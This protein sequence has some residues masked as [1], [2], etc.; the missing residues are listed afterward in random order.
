MLLKLTIFKM[1]GPMMEQVVVKLLEILCL[2]K[3]RIRV[4]NQTNFLYNSWLI[5]TGDFLILQEP[6]SAFC[7]GKT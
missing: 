5:G 3:I 6:S 1:P 4:G 7:L 2:L